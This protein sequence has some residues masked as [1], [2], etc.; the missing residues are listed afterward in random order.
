MNFRDEYIVLLVDKLAWRR[1][2][3][4]RPVVVVAV[5]DD[6]GNLTVFPSTAQEALCVNDKYFRI[7]DDDPQFGETNLDYTSCIVD[8]V[9]DLPASKKVRKLGVIRGDL[10]RRFDEEFGL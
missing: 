2:R 4:D 6:D 7:S 5:A 10:K 1:S 9:L 8:E 3:K